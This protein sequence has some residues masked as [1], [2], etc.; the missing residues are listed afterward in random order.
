MILQKTGW[1]D[2][3]FNRRA[4]VLI[5]TRGGEGSDLNVEGKRSTIAS[6]PISKAVDPT[7]CG[8]AYRGGLLYGLSQGWDW[9]RSAQLGS[10]MGAI[11]IE[12][13]GPQNH[14]PSRDA[15]AERFAAAYGEKPWA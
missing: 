1:S 5:V 6:A 2:E 8:D 9:L 3:D 15:I 14:A 13:Q 4:G 10:V 11:K 7:G 12:Q